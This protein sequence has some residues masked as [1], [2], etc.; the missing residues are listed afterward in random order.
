MGEGCRIRLEERIKLLHM[1]YAS[2]EEIAKA[3]NDYCIICKIFGSGSY[4]SHVTF[5]DAYPPTDVEPEFGVKTGIAIN[6][7]SGSVKGGAL[8]TVEFV[9]PGIYFSG[10]LYFRNLPNYAIG[11]IL[12]VIDSINAGIVRIGGFKSRGFGRVNITVSSIS[13][14]IYQNGDWISID[15]VNSLEA[16]DALD[17]TVN[18]KQP[19]D[20]I[21]SSFKEAWTKYVTAKNKY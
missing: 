11:L 7:K 5:D 2:V 21:L 13:G 16:V 20:K 17:T 6:R 12:T 8:Y 19:L 3:L 18:L 10:D 1:N 4:L 14:F 9:M 15:Q